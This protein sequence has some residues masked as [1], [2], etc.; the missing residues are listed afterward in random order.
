MREMTDFDANDLEHMI[1]QCGLDEVINTLADICFGKAE[2]LRS[3]WQDAN[4]AKLWDLAG[5]C[6]NATLA[7]RKAGHAINLISAG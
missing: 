6:I 1:D 7:D 3:N 5:V 4:T 2:H